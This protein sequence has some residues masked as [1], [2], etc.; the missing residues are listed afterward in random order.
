[1]KLASSN[2]YI[3]NLRFH[4]F[5]GVLPQERVVGNDYELSIRIGTDVEA[6]MQTDNISDTINYATVS[7]IA[8]EEMAKPR[9]LLEAVAYAI[10]NRIGERFPKVEWVDVDLRKLNP[11]TG[12][13][14][15][16]AGVVLHLI[17]N[18]TL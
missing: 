4:A 12:L 9:A 1:M 18:K 5:H 16:G 13:S 14:S 17:N 8:A 2:I 15:D 10:G 6:A 11:P 7:R 3:S